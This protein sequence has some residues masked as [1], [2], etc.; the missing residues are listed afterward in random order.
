MGYTLVELIVPFRPKQILVTIPSESMYI[1]AN[2][3]SIESSS[4]CTLATPSTTEAILLPADV[5]PPNKS[6]RLRSIQWAIESTT[7][8]HPYVPDM[9][10]YFKNFSSRSMMTLLKGANHRANINIAKLLHLPTPGISSN[11]IKQYFHLHPMSSDSDELIWQS[12]APSR[13][14]QRCFSKVREMMTIKL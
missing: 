8:T 4:I 1:K 2:S 13:I 14:L 10:Q 6:D 5:E 12:P 3:I 7:M 11:R 9:F